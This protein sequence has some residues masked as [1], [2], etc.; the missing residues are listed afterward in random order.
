MITT[1]ATAPFSYSWNT[2]PAQTTETINN[3]LSGNYNVVI[4]DQNNC[5]TTLQLTLIQPN[6]LD[7]QTQITNQSCSNYCNGKIEVIVIGGTL[8][9]IYSWN[10]TPIQTNS[11][12]INLC[13]GLYSITVKDSNNCT[14]SKQS[15]SIQT[16]THILASFTTNPNQGFSPLN[17]NFT[18]TGNGANIYNWD[19]G[20]GNT[21]NQQNPMNIYQNKGNYHIV[22]TANSGTPDFCIDTSSFDIFVDEPSDIMVPNV[23]TPNGDGVN[24]YFFA[25]AKGLID[26][27]MY[28]YN[29]WGKEIFS[30]ETLDGKWDGKCMNTDA[31]QGV[32]YYLIKAT[33]KDNKNYERHG[34][35][36]LIR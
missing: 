30:I 32:Y 20:D 28:I 6:V 18:F 36:E 2:N 27:K 19:F 5:D 34:S 11:I 33:G 1:G 17:A 4:K 15:I 7:I 13:E 12:A 23:F 24:D 21:S 8:P 16:N 29:R 3:L 35:I 26:F 22:L 14:I 31:P 10:T 25:K 9:Y